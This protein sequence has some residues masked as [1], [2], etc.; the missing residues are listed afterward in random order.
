MIEITNSPPLKGVKVLEMG[1]LIAGPFCSRI[2][3]EFGADVIKIERPKVGDPIRQWR[4]MHND[5]SIW[6]YVQSRNKKCVTIDFQT[7][8]GLAIVKSLLKECDVL[9]ENFRPGT[10][11][12]WGLSAKVLEEMNPRL[13]VCRISGFGQTGPYSDRPGFGVV[14][15]AM[16]GLRYITGYPDQAPARVGTS[17]GDH[18]ASLYSVIGILMALYHRDTQGGSGQEV[19]VALYEAVY[20]LMEAMVSEYDMKGVIRERTGSSF[21]GIVPSNLYKTGDDKELIIAANADNIFQRLLKVIDRDDL[22]G[23]ERFLTNGLRAQHEHFLDGI[24]LD[25]TQR[26]TM[27]QCLELLNA[28][29]IPCGSIYSVKEI[30]KDPHYLDRDMILE[31]EH[32]RT[33]KIKVPGIVPKLSKTPGSINWLGPDLGEHNYEVLKSIGLTDQ[34]IVLLQEKQII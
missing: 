7:E 11:A 25:W 29:G 1:S 2:L 27:E 34:Q 13:I 12:K 17:I 22:V 24:I 33:G 6:W 20:S 30:V 26:F 21:P 16:G 3:A 9:V 5:N 19:D 8:E 10:L 14:G 31:I 4:V 28:N 15:E 23:D 18:L 32:A